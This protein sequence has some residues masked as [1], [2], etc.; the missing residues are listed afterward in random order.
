ME[1]TWA[2]TS[3]KRKRKTNQQKVVA[4]QKPKRGAQKSSPYILFKRRINMKQRWAVESK[5]SKKWFCAYPLEPL[6]NSKRE[7]E[8]AIVEHKKL[9]PVGW[10]FRVVKWNEKQIV[11]C[12]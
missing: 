1:V 9:N 5:Q 6:Y 10:K 4:P 8:K 3:S 11:I 2:H 12:G 7:A